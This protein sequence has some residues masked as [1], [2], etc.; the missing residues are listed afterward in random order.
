M[1]VF[2]SMPMKG[3]TDEQIKTERKAIEEEILLIH[4]D[5]EF[6]DTL[7]TEEYDEKHSG[8][9]YLAKSIELLDQADMVYFAKGWESARGCKIEH[10]VV[11][12]YMN[13]EENAR[14]MC[15]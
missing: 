9:L 11:H 14:E 2:I 13:E 1:K 12:E 5:A 8:M 10:L 15:S 7:I 6:I 3:K 4:P